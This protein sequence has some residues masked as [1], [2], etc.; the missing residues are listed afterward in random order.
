MVLH[1]FH[2]IV[3]INH[4]PVIEQSKVSLLTVNN[5]LMRSQEVD[6]E[7]HFMPTTAQ[8]FTYRGGTP[9][10]FTE[11]SVKKNTFLNCF[12]LILINTNVAL[13]LLI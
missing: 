10:L 5:E 13:G 7:H 9:T 8:F 1:R 11:L 6:S 2:L 12:L 3:P 4:L